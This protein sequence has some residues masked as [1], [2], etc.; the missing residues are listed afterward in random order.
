[1]YRVTALTVVLFACSSSSSES[2]SSSQAQPESVPD[3]AVAVA[4]LALP[5]AA[6]IAAD[7]AC[8]QVPATKIENGHCATDADCVLTD[9]PA[10]CDACNSERLYPA[11]RTAFDRR[12]AGCPRASC[13][14]GCPPHDTY[15]RAFYR[16]ECRSHRCIAWRYHSGG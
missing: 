5:D 3:R 4:G 15:T 10:E 16:A 6:P 2:Q 7:A 11:L 1:M 12:N 13:A 8:P 14:T 9:V